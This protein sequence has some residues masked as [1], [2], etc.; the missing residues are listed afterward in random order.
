M[1]E[2]PEIFLEGREFLPKVTIAVRALTK[3]IVNKQLVFS[4]M[5]L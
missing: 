5:S 1:E 2:L 4:V 3:K